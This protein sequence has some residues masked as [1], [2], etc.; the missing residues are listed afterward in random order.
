[1]I[2]HGLASRSQ[3]TSFFLARNLKM[4]SQ[5]QTMVKQIKK[6]TVFQGPMC[7]NLAGVRPRRPDA[8]ALQLR[9]LQRELRASLVRL[10]TFRGRLLLQA[11]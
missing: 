10:E 8:G 1:M 11:G 7:T 2:L 5:I 6:D 3:K 9:A 4:R